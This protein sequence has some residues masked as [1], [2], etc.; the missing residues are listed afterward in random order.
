VN[1]D[2]RARRAALALRRWLAGSDRRIPRPKAAAWTTDSGATIALH[3]GHALKL[4]SRR[5]GRTARAAQSQLEWRSARR[6]PRSRR[7]VLSV[8][9]FD[10]RGAS[11]RPRRGPA[12]AEPALL[13]HR[14]DEHAFAARLHREPGS[15]LRL[16]DDFGRLLAHFHSR[17]PVDRHGDGA[18]RETAAY[19]A[20]EAQWL[21]D[22]AAL[23][24]APDDLR[25]VDAVVE[26]ARGWLLASGAASIGERARSGGRRH[27]HGDLHG[28][29][30]HL[31]GGQA[32][33][34]DLLPV[35]RHR[36][37][38][39]AADLGR[40]AFE[41]HRLAGPVARARLLAAYGQQGRGIPPGLV[42][43][44]EAKALLIDLT[45]LAASRSIEGP[46]GRPPWPR[47]APQLLGSLT[48]ICDALLAL[49]G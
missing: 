2:R 9:W 42:D 36:V 17:C 39:V 48:D 47:R 32:T 34:L 27:G 35:R 10:P 25:R 40:L 33:L 43:Y 1:A 28:D 41:F 5:L 19:A 16:A 37:Q 3:G 29:N 20:L 46:P 26:R 31:R 13:M 12:H 7:A 38:D 30:L 6:L 45:V 11:L 21:R 8:L 18:A 24:L 49:P 23:H 14:L 22:R 4:Q 15:A 44:F